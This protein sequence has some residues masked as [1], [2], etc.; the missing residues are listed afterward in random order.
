MSLSSQNNWQN[1]ARGQQE[2][3][4]CPWG[5]PAPGKWR[6]RFARGAG[7]PVSGALRLPPGPGFEEVLIEYGSESFGGDPRAPGA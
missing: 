1:G 5:T 2:D 6:T 3:S 7:P 4:A